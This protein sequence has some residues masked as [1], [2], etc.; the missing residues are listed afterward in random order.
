MMKYLGGGF[1]VGVPCRDLTKEE[2][3]KFGEAFLLASGLYARPAAKA[4]TK[5]GSGGKEDKL[6]TG[7]VENKE[8]E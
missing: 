1:L 8:G 7:P 6:A 3:K 5:K 2:V 4:P